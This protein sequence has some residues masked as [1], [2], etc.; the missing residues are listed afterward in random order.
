MDLFILTS[1]SLI[2][3]KGILLYNSGFGIKYLK[4][5]DIVKSLSFS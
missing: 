1:F 5:K 3:I 4:S 2:L